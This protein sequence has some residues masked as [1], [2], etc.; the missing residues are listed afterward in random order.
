MFI[1]QWKNNKVNEEES[2]QVEEGGVD[3]RQQRVCFQQKR[4]DGRQRDTAEICSWKKEKKQ[5][6]A[7][8]PKGL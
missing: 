3:R 4:L 1:E 7:A 2:R 6:W 8:V 5:E